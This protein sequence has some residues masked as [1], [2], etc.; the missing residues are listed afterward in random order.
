MDTNKGDGNVPR[1]IDLEEGRL[2]RALKKGFRNWT[3]RFGEEFGMETRPSQISFKTLS[4]LAQSSNDGTFYMYDLIMHLQ[5]LGSGFEFNELGPDQKMAVIDR[6][7]LLLDRIR[8]ECMKRLGWLESYPG[9][10]CTLVELITQFDKLAPVLQAKLPLLSRDYPGYERYCAMN[11]LDK[12]AF[13]RKLIPKA[14]KEVE[15]YSTTL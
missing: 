7:L 2:L 14:L 11:T 6:H 1:V 8:F 5:E 10:E 9:E 13:V 12:E 4:Y 3:S 15:A